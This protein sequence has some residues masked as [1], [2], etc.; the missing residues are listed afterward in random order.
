MTREER[1]RRKRRKVLLYR[2]ILAVGLLLAL[3]LLFLLLKTAVTAISGRE[4][5]QNGAAGLTDSTQA[6]ESLPAAGTEGLQTEETEEAG[7]ETEQTTTTFSDVTATITI[8][9]VGDCTLGRNQK[10]TYENSFDEA[11][12]KYGKT[13]FLEKVKDVF[14][15]DDFTIANLEGVLTN[16]TERVE[17]K[18]NHKGKP[19]YT[20][21]LTYGSVEAVTLGNNHSAD[22]GEK[23]TQ[24][25]IDA[26]EEAGIVWAMNED[27]GYYKTD[28][29]VT[30]GYVSVNIV[31]YTEEKEK[32]LTDGLAI[33]RQN[34]D[35]VICCPHWGVQDTYDAT[36]DQQ[37]LA[38]RLIDAGADLVIGCH[39]HRLQGLEVYKGKVIVYSMGNFCYG[40]AK[41]P[42]DRNSMIYQQTFT[43]VNGQLQD[44]LDATVIPCLFSKTI[45]N[46]FQPIIATG[47][48]QEIIDL[49]NEYSAPLGGATLDEEGHL[50]E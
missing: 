18:F 10:H 29:G 13:Y 24:D 38:Y 36:E 26:L 43:F 15:A 1:R 28:S 6:A 39:A 3:C 21:I 25:T 44:T 40:G 14:E 31:E 8:S 27:L 30:I 46:T 11:Y 37:Q 23:S 5:K 41:R 4:Q 22:Y 45:Q 33:L 50:Q 42:G 34:A 9:A 2:A 48:K 17:K 47:S 32:L 12:D 16:E 19:E 20:G 35:L 49:L 7:S